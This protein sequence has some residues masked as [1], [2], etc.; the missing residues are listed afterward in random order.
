M[1]EIR[2]TVP[3][4]GLD[5][6]GGRQLV[7]IF[8]MY[9]AKFHGNSCSQEVSQPELCGRDGKPKEQVIDIFGICIDGEGGWGGRKR[10]QKQSF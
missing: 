3:T 9:I 8:P 4:S 6:N 1:A 10:E 7:R 2:S 5:S